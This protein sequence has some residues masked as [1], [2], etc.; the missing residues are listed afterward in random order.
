MT[1]EEE[2]RDRI[3]HVVDT[4]VTAWDGATSTEIAQAI[5]DNLG[6]EIETASGHEDC[7]CRLETYP[8]EHRVV[9]KWVE[10][11]ES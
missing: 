8:A 11:E 4:E 1:N 5:I 2:L 3:A 7:G 6:L 10:E 9:G